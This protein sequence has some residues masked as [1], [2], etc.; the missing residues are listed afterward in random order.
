MSV[1]R[2]KSR[3]TSQ[4]DKLL[5]EQVSIVGVGLIGGS[6][7]LGIKRKN[8]AKEVVGFG[9]CQKLILLLQHRQCWV[10]RSSCLL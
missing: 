7:G 3:F 8:L 5:F 4:R 2:K 10:L 1:K 6:I 9:Q